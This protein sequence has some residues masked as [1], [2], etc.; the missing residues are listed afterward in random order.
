MRIS[1]GEP[2]LNERAGKRRSGKPRKGNPWLRAALTEA[3]HEAALAVAHSILVIAYQLLLR[4]E[5]YRDLG[6]TYFDDRDRRRVE[7][8]LERLGHRVT[9]EPVAALG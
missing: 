3:A 1:D 5:A 4:Q 2:R 8:R 7:R 9:L 6:G